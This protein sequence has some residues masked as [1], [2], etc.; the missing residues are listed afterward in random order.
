MPPS[1][2]N[3]TLHNKHLETF[4]KNNNNMQIMQMDEQDDFPSAV[5]LACKLQLHS[6]IRPGRCASVPSGFALP[7]FT[8]SRFACR[9]ARL[10]LWGFLLIRRNCHTY[11]STQ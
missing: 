6:C 9:F 11:S 7:R 8:P 2:N 5:V 1:S 4:K 10:A 3:L